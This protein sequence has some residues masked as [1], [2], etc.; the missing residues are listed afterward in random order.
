ME[1]E[2]AGKEQPARIKYRIEAKT[3]VFLG[4]SCI[5]IISLYLVG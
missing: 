3:K 2:K 1:K 5:K 4:I